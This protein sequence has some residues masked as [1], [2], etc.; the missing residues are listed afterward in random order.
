MMSLAAI[1]LLLTACGGG[2]ATSPRPGGAA[3]AP[4]SPAPSAPS[5]STA[6]AARATLLWVA[7]SGS[8]APAWITYDGGYFR[9]NGVDVN[10]EYVSGSPVASAALA[11]GSAQFATIAGPAVVSAD[12]KGAHEV[13][14]MGFVNKPLFV[15][16]AVPSI[17]QPQQLRGKTVGVVKIGTSDDFMFRE[18]LSHWGLTAGGGPT[19]VHI[20]GVGSTPAQLAA[21]Q[22]GLI[23]ALV[24][25]PPNDVLAAKAGAH[26]LVRIA[27]LGIEYQANS[28]VTTEAEIKNHPQTVLRVV[29]S[30]AEGLHR[31]KTDK[32]YAEQVMGKYL[33]TTNQSVLDSAWQTYS[34]IFPDAP[35][36]TLAGM[37][38]IARED[39]AAGIIKGSADV[40]SMVD[41]SFVN[42]LQK[43]GFLAKLNG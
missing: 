18:A 24:V 15:V 22:K 38:E 32:A 8:Q 13:V 35:T 31:F 23:Q 21:L 28:L 37:Q 10:M 33:K 17:T 6:A 5:G 2:A 26:L 20:T 11:G 19:D 14:V 25:D 12:A 39:Q 36:P 34:A 42:Q 29:E 40:G 16:M 1:A 3:P 43:N 27:D 30:F 41:P 9:Q 7:I 4:S